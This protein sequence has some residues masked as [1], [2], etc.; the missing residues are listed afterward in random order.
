LKIS[1]KVEKVQLVISTHSFPAFR[2]L[3]INRKP[4]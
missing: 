4:E 2:I 1:S 3:F